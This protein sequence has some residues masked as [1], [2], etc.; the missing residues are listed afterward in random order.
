MKTLSHLFVA[1]LLLLIMAS[2][3]MAS[4]RADHFEGKPADTLEEALANFST[5]NARLAE[6]IAGDQLDTLAVFEV[7]QLTYTLEN[8]LE[9]IREELAELAEVL[10][11]V[12]VASEHNDGETV[13]ARGRVYLKTARTLLPE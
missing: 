9:K 8:A 5:Y 3:A 7:H 2:L 4:E 6:I 12:H 10:E 11:E 13:Q 1:A